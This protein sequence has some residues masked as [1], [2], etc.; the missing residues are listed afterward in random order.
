MI[1]ESTYYAVVGTDDG[2]TLA[3]IRVTRRGPRG[4]MRVCAQEYTGVTYRSMRAAM[5][6]LGALNANCRALP[7]PV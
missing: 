7:V 5:K 6:D 4:D 2:K 1:L 3:Q